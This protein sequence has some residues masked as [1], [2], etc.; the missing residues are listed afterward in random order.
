MAVPWAQAL[1]VARK[2]S[3]SIACISRRCRTDKG[4]SACVCLI[5]MLSSYVERGSDQQEKSFAV[6]FFKKELLSLLRCTSISDQTTLSVEGLRFARSVSARIITRTTE[7]HY[8]LNVQRSVSF[9]PKWRF[10]RKCKM[11]IPC[12]F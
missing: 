9:S 8:N 11:D 2:R 1:S 3:R 10:R 5:P 4:H 6:L 12:I 7:P